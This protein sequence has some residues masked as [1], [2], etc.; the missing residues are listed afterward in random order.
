MTKSLSIMKKYSFLFFVFILAFTCAYAQNQEIPFEVANRYFLKSNYPEQNLH[1]LKIT[2]QEQFDSIFGMAPIMGKDGQPTFIDFAK[3][4]VITVIDDVGTRTENLSIKSLTKS[5]DQLYVQ[6]ELKLRNEP[7][8]AT[9]RFCTLIVVDNQYFGTVRASPFSQDGT[10]IVGGDLDERGCKPSTGTTWSILKNRCMSPWESEYFLEGDLSYP[11]LFN[12]DNSKAEIIGLNHL[13]R[14]YSEQL[15][16]NK[17]GNSWKNGH[18][19]LT[20]TSKGQFILEDH[21]QI[22]LKG[23]YRK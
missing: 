21:N 1:L 17:V 7:S 10:P 18:I 6:Y 13:N 4:F 8:S 2:D 23:K 14:K 12:E 5:E 20:E 19:K 16:L 15:I 22:I 11:L 3:Q 9:Y